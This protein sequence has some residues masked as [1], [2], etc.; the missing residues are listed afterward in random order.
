MYMQL[1]RKFKIK[2]TNGILQ[3]CPPSFIVINALTTT[4]KRII[5][6]IKKPVVVAT[7]GFLPPPKELE[8]PSCW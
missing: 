8:T 6:D 1:Q 7:K 5:D 2:A 3:R 4:L